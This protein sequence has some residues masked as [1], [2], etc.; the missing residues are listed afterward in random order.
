MLS[1]KVCQLNNW[2]QYY[3]SVYAEGNELY[4][5]YLIHHIPSNLINTSTSSRNLPLT[6]LLQDNKIFGSKKRYNG[7]WT[8]RQIKGYKEVCSMRQVAD[9][10]GYKTTKPLYKYLNSGELPIHATEFGHQYFIL[11]E[12][13]AWASEL[14]LMPYVKP[15]YSL[16]DIHEPLQEIISYVRRLEISDRMARDAQKN[17]GLDTSEIIDIDIFKSMGSDLLN[18]LDEFHEIGDL[19]IYDPQSSLRKVN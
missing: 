19:K 4:S 2:M 6:R 3:L 14:R 1:T 10:L 17:Q 16:E 15:R 13:T 12:I 7:K 18:I 9:T 5:S 8:I 11:D